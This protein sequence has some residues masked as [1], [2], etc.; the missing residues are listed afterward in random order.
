MVVAL[1]GKGRFDEPDWFSIAAPPRQMT[2]NTRPLR[3]AISPDGK[4]LVFSVDNSGGMESLRI[5]KVNEPSDQSLVLSRHVNYIGL[6]FSKDSGTIYAVEKEESTN[7]GKLFTIPLIGELPN[8]PV[9]ENIDGPVTFSPS[10]DRFAFVRWEPGS[11]ASQ[12]R[13]V[14]ELANADGSNITPLVVADRF[15]IFAQPSWTSGGKG[16]AAVIHDLSSPAYQLSVALFSITKTQR[17]LPLPDWNSVGQIAWEKTTGLL[18]LSSASAIEANNRQQIREI[19]PETGKTRDTTEDLSGYSS[20]SLTDDG[21]FVAAVRKDWQAG[22][23]ISS[24]KDLRIGQ[25]T[26]SEA[27]EKGSLGWLDNDTLVVDSRRTGYSNLISI[28]ANDRRE[29]TLTNDPF[30]EQHA[31]PVPGTKSVVF[32]SNRFGSFHIVRFDPASNQVHTA[33]FRLVL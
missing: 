15:R 12:M 7:M 18:M 28:T 20:V 31:V 10:G 3:C 9:V 1:G 5:K 23:W 11:D 13:S 2:F 26:S 29:S 32:S 21:Q 4:Y 24:P 25:I 27:Q 19:D 33:Y 6:T 14:L 16:I 22:L 8:R 30:M 17:Q